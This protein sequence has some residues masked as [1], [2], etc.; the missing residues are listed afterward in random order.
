[1]VTVEI[2]CFRTKLVVIMSL[3]SCIPFKDNQVMF[4]TS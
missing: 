2:Y 1:M 3:A 4:I